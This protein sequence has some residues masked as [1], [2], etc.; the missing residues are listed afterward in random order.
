[1]EKW[2]KKIREYICQLEKDGVVDFV[3]PSDLD[4]VFPKEKVFYML[5]EAIGFMDLYK[6]N[7]YRLMNHSLTEEDLILIP[8]ID[9]IYEFE[10][11]HQMAIENEAFMAKMLE[12]CKN[13]SQA[14]ALEKIAQ[15]K[16]LP[17]QD[18]NFLEEICPCFKEELETYGKYVN[19]ETYFQYMR[20]IDH[21]YKREGI[22]H[23]KETYEIE[24][25][26]FIRNLYYWDQANALDNIYELAYIDYAWSKTYLKQLNER[27]IKKYPDVANGRR[28]AE[29]RVNLFEEA[30]DTEII[31]TAL[32]EEFYLPELVDTYF[33]VRENFA[34]EKDFLTETEQLNLASEKGK[35]KMKRFQ[36]RRKYHE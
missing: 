1:M 25:A 27:T 17:S 36:E 12:A 11:I 7:H 5:I 10:H 6:Q 35:E 15:V 28:K 33:Y 23:L 19:L 18:Q 26:W 21:F 4:D 8:D 30:E 31:K 24:I 29:R 16:S 3:I 20:N 13:F 22:L 14:T 2:N 9:R 34:T 32:L